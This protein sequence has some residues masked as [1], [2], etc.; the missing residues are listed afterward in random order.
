MKDGRKFLCIQ[1]QKSQKGHKSRQRHCLCLYPCL[2]ACVCALCITLCVRVCL[3]LWLC[4]SSG[5]FEKVKNMRLWNFWAVLL[6]A[7]S[8]ERRQPRIPRP[9]SLLLQHPVQTPSSD[10][11]EDTPCVLLQVCLSPAC[12]ADGAKDTWDRLQALAPA[13]VRIQEGSCQSGCGNGPLVMES[14]ISNTENNINNNNNNNNQTQVVRHRRVTSEKA[15]ELLFPDTP[16]P[17]PVLIQGYDLARQADALFE[18]QQYAACIPLYEQ[19]IDIAFRAAM[20]LQAARDARHRR[21]LMGAPTPAPLG[22]AWLVRSRRNEALAKLHVRDIDGA[23]LA[24]QAACNL[25]RNTSPEAFRVLALIYRQRNDA[26]GELQS[27]RT[28]LSLPVDEAQLSSQELSDRRDCQF[29]LQRLQRE[30]ENKEKEK[31]SRT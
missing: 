9:P 7:P 22:L 26:A 30:L 28:M 17:P 27:L 12:R 5:A 16:G 3:S 21:R 4:G 1:I 31:K 11:K 8:R 13:H 18:G 20:D 19:V 23:M 2:L 10:T 25:S 15:L 6:S 29:R 24:A 14:S